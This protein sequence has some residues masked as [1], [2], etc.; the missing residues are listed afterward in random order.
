[1]KTLGLAGSNSLHSINKALVKYTIQLFD[2]IQTE[3]LDLNDFE[4]PIF[5]VDTESEQGIH[6]KTQDLA[7]RIDAADLLVISLAE[8]NDSYSAAFKN[9]YDWLSRIPNRKVFNG[10][11]MLLMAT[12]PGGRGGS[13]VLAAAL[14][15]FPR[16]GAKILETFSLP[17][18]QENFDK[19]V[20]ITNTEL[21]I[22]LLEK[23][24]K[25]NNKL[26]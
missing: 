4:I 20:G 6:Q 11:P 8:H 9:V 21:K 15:R 14:E 17:K 18:F 25:I 12:S 2:A 5:S 7:N 13:S 19:D 10:K 26:S 23:I 22:E 3:L 24:N 16:D 1:M